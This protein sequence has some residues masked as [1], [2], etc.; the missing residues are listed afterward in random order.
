MCSICG[1]IDF[2]ETLENKTDV[3]IKMGKTMKHRGVD[4]DGVFE[5]KQ[6]A[7]QHNRLAVMDIE[8]GKQPMSAVY[9]GAK[10]TICYNGE[11]YNYEELKKDLGEKGINFKTN[12]DTEVVLYTY[13]M[14]GEECVKQLNGIFAF[15]IYDEKN[16][17]VYLARD[18]FGIKPFFYSIVDSTFKRR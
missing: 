1:M 7:F 5:F 18:R 16:D 11:I 6:G 9:N 3:V 12:C 15:A 10:Y 14:Y 13:I 2:Y 4:D 8:N 17:F